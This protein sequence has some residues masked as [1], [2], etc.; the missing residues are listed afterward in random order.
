MKVLLLS[1]PG[2]G[3]Y[4][5]DYYCSK[6]AKADYSYAPVDLLL[7]SGRFEDVRFIDAIQD[8]LTPEVCLDKIVALAPAAVISLVGATSWAEDRAFL[9]AVKR[10]L[11]QTKILA[12]GDVLLEAGEA[13]M[14]REDWLDAI[15]LDFTNP[16]AERYLSG[17]FDDIEQ[18][19]FRK[20]PGQIV[21]RTSRRRRGPIIDLPQPRQDLFISQGYVYPFVRHRRFATVQTDYGCPFACR[22]CVM[23]QLGYGLRPVAEVMREL[24]GLQER[25]VREIYFNDQ[26]FGADPAHLQAVCQAMI[27]DRLDLGWCCWSRVDTAYDHLALMKRAGCHT[28]MFGVESANEETLRRHRKGFSL[29]QVQRAFARCR[30]LGLRTLGTFLIGLPGEDRADIEQTIDL[31]LELKCDFASFNVLVPRKGTA[32]RQELAARGVRPDDIIALDQT[33]HTVAVSAVDLSPQELKSLRDLA[34]RR[35]YRR[36]G[37][38]VR[39]LLKARTW[40]DLQVLGRMGLSMLWS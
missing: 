9:S 19:I 30:E 37:Y 5:R 2:R 29:T 34:M 39:R 31:S 22:F 24:K 21:V 8:E 15:V 27:Q 4:I 36:P 16:D 10:A 14:A 12:S 28:V 38:I 18:M 26:T 3:Q 25:G 40:Y 23:A 17:R 20:N 13:V 1:P 11:P 7:L 32:V 33:G 6:V 35:F